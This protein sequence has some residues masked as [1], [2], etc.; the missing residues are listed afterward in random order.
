MFL[1]ID[2]VSDKN[3]KKILN[4]VSLWRTNIFLINVIFWE[5]SLENIK[6]LLKLKNIKILFH[7]YFH[8]RGEFQDDYISQRN[9]FLK[10]EKIFSLVNINKKIFSPPYNLINYNTIKLLRDFK[11][12]WLSLDYKNISRYDLFDCKIK[13][14]ETNYFF[15]KKINNDTWFIWQEE[16]IEKEINF[17]KKKNIDIWV[18]IHPDFINNIEDYKKYIFLLKILNINYDN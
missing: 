6:F 8:K 13:L 17:L 18:E 11:Y 9:I 4:L 15:N 3:I 14:Y 5:T 1:R 2:D 10:A 16:D 7:W 12:Y